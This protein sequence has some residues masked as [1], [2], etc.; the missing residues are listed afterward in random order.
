MKYQDYLKYRCITS[1]NALSKATGIPVHKLRY[2]SCPSNLD[3]KQV[4]ILKS[5][6]GDWDTFVPEIEHVEREED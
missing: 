6:I 1:H 3:Y 5:I 2:K 4:A